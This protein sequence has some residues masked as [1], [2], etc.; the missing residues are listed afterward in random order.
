MT[1]VPA[2]PA[3]LCALPALAVAETPSQCLIEPNQK[4]ELKSPVSATL[5]AVLVERGSVVRRGQP[6]VTL[7]SEVE[8]ASLNVEAQ[9]R[10]SEI[11]A[12]LGLD[13]GAPASAPAV[14]APAQSEPEPGT[15]TS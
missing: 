5:T 14:S 4:I 15:A 11:R 8:Q 3:L 10:L 12:Q 9:S 6:L 2:W 13:A 7:D 1:R